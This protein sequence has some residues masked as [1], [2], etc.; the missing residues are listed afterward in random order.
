MINHVVSMQNSVLYEYGADIFN[1]IHQIGWMQELSVFLAF[2]TAMLVL[3]NTR[4]GYK[5]PVRKIMPVIALLALLSGFVLYLIGFAHRGNY[6]H[7]TYIIFAV[8]SAAEMFLLKSNYGFLSDVCKDSPGFMLMFSVTYLAAILCSITFLLQAIGIRFGAWIKIAVT[9][10][11]VL[12]GF[13]YELY[14]FVYPTKSVVQ[15]AKS[16]YKQNRHFKKK[17]KL[18]FLC[19]PSDDSSNNKSIAQI[20]G[21][22]S[23]KKDALEMIF[24]E[25]M[26]SLVA[27][28]ENDIAICN[29]SIHADYLKMAGIKKTK[30]LFK[31]ASSVKML[32]LTENEKLNLEVAYKMAGDKTIVDCNES[33]KQV[34]IYCMA[35]KCNTNLTLE[36]M[37][38]KSNED[39]H[40][41]DASYLSVAALKK[42]PAYLP[43]NFVDHENGVVHSA[44]HS[45]IVGFNETGQEA[46]KFLYEFGAFLGPDGKRSPF[47]CTIV[48]SQM[49]SL[50][51]K[52]YTDIPGLK[53][54]KGIRL[55]QMMAGTA[56]FWN[57]MEQ[58]IKELNYIVI[59]SDNDDDNIALAIDI[60]KF[61]CRH[62]NNDLRRFKI[63]VKSYNPDNEIKLV[64]L[65]HY[66][67]SANMK[68]SGGGEIVVFGKEQEIYSY[69]MLILDEMM[70]K[71]KKAYDT[72]NQLTGGTQTW[73]ERR[74][75]HIEDNNLFS[76]QALK[77]KE[78]QDFSNA[79]HIDTK[80]I[81][82][83]IKN[84]DRITNSDAEKIRHM[85]EVFKQM[86]REGKRW[87]G[88][89]TNDE[90]YILLENLAKNE[91]LRWNAS[92]I[93]LGYLPDKGGNGCNEV[94]KLHSCLVS[95]DE[96]EEYE[97]DYK[98]YDYMFVEMAL[99]IKEEQIKRG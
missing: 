46:L 24:R 83:G 69:R 42:N 92:H 60:Y 6:G 74:K 29:H 15:L 37:M 56:E 62:R 25:N 27:F 67:N 58:F 44:F 48:D 99:K 7:A 81:L 57:M 38:L 50:K 2:I 68:E 34:D 1:Q 85:R 8:I 31:Y 13:D 82:A 70:Q 72:Y 55:L 63:F 94:M 71:A 77:R 75:K 91:H 10:I 87:V 65:Q 18:L 9:R 41:M 73:Q 96:L 89:D 26:D 23:E 43:V 59:A 80:M 53:E 86:H 22:N 11:T 17:V 49:D 30:R 66:Y 16:I 14:V 51:G 3:C 39:I 79:Y 33:N 90:T 20:L 5:F 19:R 47:H 98:Y 61:A 95:W 21:M 4:W 12:L 52:F 78:G 45:L 93:L 35:R 88:V 28:C 84:P 40:V 97:V 76:Y 54:E 64:S 36:D 32:I